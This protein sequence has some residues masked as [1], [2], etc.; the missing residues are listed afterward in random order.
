M[1]RMIISWKT[2]HIYNTSHT[3]TVNKLPAFA[4]G[5]LSCG[6]GSSSSSPSSSCTCLVQ[7]KLFCACVQMGVGPDSRLS[8]VFTHEQRTKHRTEPNA[9]TRAA[10]LFFRRKS[11]LNCSC[12]ACL[13][14]CDSV[15]CVHT[16]CEWENLAVLVCQC[17]VKW[18]PTL[19]SC[20]CA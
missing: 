19:Y 15:V 14:S 4:C 18:F 2:S 13:T 10:L 11:L 9:W 6:Q 20:V 8:S 17:C 1:H 16:S 7:G 5:L 3:L 12:V